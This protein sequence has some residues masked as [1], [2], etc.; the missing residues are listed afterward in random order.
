MT[1]SRRYPHVVDA[2]AES[3]R[4]PRECHGVTEQPSRFEAR[5]ERVDDFVDRIAALLANQNR[6]AVAH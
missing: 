1:S 4:R 6:L 2:V 5:I 3:D